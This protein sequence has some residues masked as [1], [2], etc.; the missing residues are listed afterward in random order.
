MSKKKKINHFGGLVY[1]T[2][3]NAMSEPEF[4][5]TETLAPHLQKL[6]VFI[7]R[8]QRKGKTVTLV[9]NFEGADRDIETLGKTLKTKCGTGGNVKDGIILIQGDFKEKIIAWLKE[10]GYTQTK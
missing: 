7:D 3:P 10:M 4:E 2:D 6:R 5:D 8:K 9:E 1:S